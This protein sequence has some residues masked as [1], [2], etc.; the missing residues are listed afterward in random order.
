MKY[1]PYE[2]IVFHSILSD[3]EIV[4]RLYNDL[5]AKKNN[6]RRS[7]LINT[8]DHKLFKG[9]L[10]NYHFKINRIQYISLF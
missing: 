4:D 10:H 9:G 6:R 1:F 2:H 5:E 3:D 8:E 7:I